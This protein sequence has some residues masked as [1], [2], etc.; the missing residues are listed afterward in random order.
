[1]YSWWSSRKSNSKTRYQVNFEKFFKIYLNLAGNLLA[2][3]PKPPN[4]CT[5]NF[6]CDYHR[7]LAKSG[8]FNSNWSK[9]MKMLYFS[10]WKFWGNKSSR[11][12]SNFGEILEGLILAKPISELCN[13][14]MTLGSFSDACKIAKLKSLL[15]KGS[16]MNPSNYWPIWL[17]PL[18]LKVFELFLTT[19]NFLS[20]NKTLYDYQPGFRKD[21]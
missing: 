4:L 12:C 18:L 6:V 13:L 2:K 11:N 3:L 1:M 7:K 20:L 17:L 16:K 15:K 9:Q 10:Y 8:R 14:S 21:H 5:I 19:N